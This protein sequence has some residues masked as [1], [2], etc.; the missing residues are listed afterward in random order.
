MKKI[1]LGKTGIPVSPLCFGTLPFSPL[2]G[3]TGGAGPAGEALLRAFELGVNFIDT[4]QL[5]DNYGVLRPALVRCGD[6][7]VASKTYAFTSQDAL[8]AV[9]EARAKLNRDVIDIFLL[10]EQ[11]G[12]NTLRGHAPAL[13]E[14]YRL[15]AR[16][17]IRAVGISTHHIEGMRAAV[18]AGLDVA[19][20]LL[21]IDGTGI[22]DGSRAEMENAVNAA[23]EAG[24]G[25]YTMKVLAGGGLFRRAAEALAYAREWG[26]CF[27]L[28]M[29]D[30]AEV[31]A[32]ARFIKTGILPP[33]KEQN[34]RR[35]HIADWCC[36]CGKCVE[37]CANKALTVVNGRA[38]C[39]PPECV[40]CGYCGSVCEGLCIKVI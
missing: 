39:T 31:E 26:H 34:P 29:R 14:L 13:E 8:A 18:K 2:L 37:K 12:E 36:G 21:N 40:L 19:H 9:E 10:H 22:A 27:A 32:A 7:V 11:T 24:V 5:Y 15:K 38:V 28:G 25:V 16:G 20:P 30:V 23:V 3:Y 33:L 1:L 17:V 35:L 4:A 6:A